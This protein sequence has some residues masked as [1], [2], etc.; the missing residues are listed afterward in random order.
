MGSK[1]GPECLAACNATGREASDRI[2]FGDM[3]DGR[4]SISFPGSAIGDYWTEMEV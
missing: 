4:T 1:D 2:N 3:L